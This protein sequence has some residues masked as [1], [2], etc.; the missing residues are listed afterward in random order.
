MAFRLLIMQTATKASPETVAGTVFMDGRDNRP[1]MTRF[2][3]L[4]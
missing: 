1:A 4:R 3:V 2:G